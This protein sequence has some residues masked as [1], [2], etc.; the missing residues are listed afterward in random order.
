MSIADYHGRSI[1]LILSLLCGLTSYLAGASL[2]C[3]KD[4]ASPQAGRQSSPQ[5][6]MRML[7]DFEK[8]PLPAAPH[9]PSAGSR[10]QARTSALQAVPVGNRS[11]LMLQQL[12]QKFG[13]MNGGAGGPQALQMLQ[14]RMPGA[15]GGAGGAQ[16]MQ[17]LQ[18]MQAG[19]GQMGA[20][21]PPFAQRMQQGLQA[22][23]GQ[24]AAGGAPQFMQ[25]MQ[26][27][28]GMSPRMNPG[29][30]PGMNFGMN[31]GMRPV[32]PAGSAAP[33]WA[34]AGRLP[35]SPAAAGLRMGVP[36][37]AAPGGKAADLEKMM[38]EQY[39]K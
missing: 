8:R 19:R 26:K 17:M 38:E 39:G 22:G 20:A 33:A 18:K 2:A 10:I 15:N 24:P 6:L 4:A 9:P 23:G 36:G 25:M 14:Q 13:G 12:K 3:A 29:M 30:S 5:D 7:D 16:F 28:Q 37:R 1:R 27:M 31:P 35:G 21:G 34:G 32:A 11:S